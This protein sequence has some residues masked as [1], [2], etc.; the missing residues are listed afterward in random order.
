MPTLLRYNALMEKQTVHGPIVPPTEAAQELQ[1]TRRSDAEQ[2]AVTRH[3][4]INMI[5]ERTQQDIA[6]LCVAASVFSSVYLV[7][8]G[9]E[10]LAER[11]FQFLTNVGLLV[12]GFYFGR[13]NHTRPTGKDNQ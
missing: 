11:G 7:V 6:I 1:A 4:G 2:L 5:W 8:F 13:T 12:I 3:Q 10:P 9:D